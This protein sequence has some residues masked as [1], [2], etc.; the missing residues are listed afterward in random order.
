MFST[1]IWKSPE[2]IE[3]FCAILAKLYDIRESAVNS[4]MEEISQKYLLSYTNDLIELVMAVVDGKIHTDNISLDNALKTSDIIP[5]TI[6]GKVCQ[7][8]VK[9]F[10]VTIALKNDQKRISS[11]IL[12][13]DALNQ[14]I[15]MI[16]ALVS[17]GEI[18]YNIIYD[19][20]DE[21]ELKLKELT[22]TNT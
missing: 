11:S 7:T 21:I 19:R 5:A 3:D 20:L 8:L 17:G 13:I 1:I 15:S 9:A 22:K 12:L 14:Y 2:K 4:V 6:I 16:I 18:N 10:K